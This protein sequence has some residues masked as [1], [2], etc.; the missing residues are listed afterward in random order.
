MMKKTELLN[1]D[2]LDLAGKAHSDYDLWLEVEQHL[3]ATHV[4]VDAWAKVADSSIM[5]M[6][7]SSGSYLPVIFPTDFGAD[8][9]GVKN[10]FTA[11]SCSISA[12]RATGRTVYVPS[13]TFNIQYS[14]T[15]SYLMLNHPGA[16]IMG[17]GR[18]NTVIKTSHVLGNALTISGS[19]DAF[20]I[21]SRD[22]TISD[23]TLSGSYIGGFTYELSNAGLFPHCNGVLNKIPG[24]T[25]TPR[26]DVSI[27]RC[28][29]MG[30]SYQFAAYAGPVNAFGKIT[31]TISDTE[32]EGGLH[33]IV[34]YSD[35]NANDKYLFVDR[36]YLHDTD[37]NSGSHLIY[38]HPHTSFCITRT[39]FGTPGHSD[40]NCLDNWGSTNVRPKFQIV[41]QCLFEND[42][43]T[44][45]LQNEHN[46][47]QVSNTVFNGW[48]GIQ[49]RNSLLMS[50]VY[51]RQK[52]GN[53]LATYADMAYN[54]HV[55]LNN[56]TFDFSRTNMTGTVGIH[57]AHPVRITGKGLVFMSDDGGQIDN[58]PVPVSSVHCFNFA[59]GSDR[60][61]VNIDGAIATF[62]T[63]SLSS[64]DFMFMFTSGAGTIK[65]NNL[66]WGGS[67]P[68][69]NGVFN[70]AN[71]T[72]LKLEITNSYISASRGF[73][74]F[75]D[76]KL[77]PNSIRGKE[78]DF[79]ESKLTCSTYQSIRLREEMYGDIQSAPSMSLSPSY[80]IYNVL[81]TASIYHA[82]VKLSG[83]TN[84]AFGGSVVKFIMNGATFT[85]SAGSTFNQDYVPAVG[86]MVSWWW[87]SSASIFRKL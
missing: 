61:N 26:Y 56:V 71:T 17:A 45:I 66:Q 12:S 74:I 44:S 6:R 34:Y 14:A 18:D 29:I 16:R 68:S 36:C 7:A 75:S 63:S 42:Y 19:Y 52:G 50:N 64:A 59:T 82:S 73:P 86:E 5:S 76:S 54:S 9:T 21:G 84:R 3:S 8:A 80:S 37:H 46:M 38:A 27:A 40:D 31:A 60:C 41:D 55:Q 51:F 30:H 67:A 39:I 24:N 78:N 87:D 79:Q 70:V 32:M 11:F 53:C 62:S 83:N 72:N 23:L 15:A 2:V 33:C 85:S 43:G 1:L 81:G 10:C 13:G 58:P 77:L 25:T 35:V 20:L 28:K 48:G 47:L 65:V 22:V 4:A 69:V 49:L 57:V